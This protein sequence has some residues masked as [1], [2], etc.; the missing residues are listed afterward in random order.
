MS[1]KSA[2]G[3][4][5]GYV[6]KSSSPYSGRSAEAGQAEEPQQLSWRDKHCPGPRVSWDARVGVCLCVCLSVCA[7]GNGGRTKIQDQLMD[8]LCIESQF[9]EGSKE[10]VFVCLCVGACVQRGLYQHLEWGCRAGTQCRCQQLGTLGS[11]GNYWTD[12]VSELEGSMLHGCIYTHIYIPLICLYPD[13]PQRGF[14]G[15]LI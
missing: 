4:T 11:R 14:D 13:Q 1:E 10:C 5:F 2:S 7:W 3:K 8:E 6:I 9:L 12:Q 15:S